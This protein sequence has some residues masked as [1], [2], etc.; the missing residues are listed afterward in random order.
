MRNVHTFGTIAG[1]RE[2]T[3][4]LLEL[5]RVGDKMYIH[6][7]KVWQRYSPTMFLPHLMKDDDVVGI[8]SSA[9]AAALFANF[10][11]GVERTDYWDVIMNKAREALDAP[12]DQRE[13]TKK[14]LMRHP[15]RRYA[16]DVRAL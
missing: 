15:V 11:H 1:I 14:R 13:E 8:T 6:P 9:Q 3:Q 4:L 16:P 2:T 12:P 5:L 10:S 7:L